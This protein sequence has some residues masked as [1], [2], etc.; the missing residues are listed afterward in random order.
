MTAAFDPLR[1]DHPLILYIDFKS[2]YAYLAK[3]PAYALEDDLGIEIDWRPLTLD[4]PSYLGSARL[5]ARG[6]VAESNRTPQ[7]WSGV[8]YAYRDARRY[9]SL[10]GLT[11]RG[12]TKI[13]D[14]SLAGIGMQWAKLQ[15]RKILRSYIDRVYDPFWKRELDIEDPAVIERVLA[16]AGADLEGFAAYHTGAGRADNDRIQAQIFEAGVFGVPSFIVDGE[17]FF[18]REH[19][20][21]IRWLLTGRV[22]PAPDIAYR[23]FLDYVS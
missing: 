13:W 16:E 19:L 6:K 2:P 9:A 1:S 12:T 7:Q 11:I 8:K 15:G 5:D 14:S 3:D 23:N 22:G 4:I 17:L 18:G 10:R 21:R 20:P